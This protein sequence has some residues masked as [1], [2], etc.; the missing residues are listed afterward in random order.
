MHSLTEQ[1]KGRKCSFWELI[2]EYFIE[3]PIIQRDY[4]QGR[5]TGKA[6]EIRKKFLPDLVNAIKNNNP[7][8]LDFIYGSVKEGV[9]QP[10]DGQQR[11][12]TLFLLHWYIAQKEKQLNAEVTEQLQK[13]TY[14]TRTSSR[15]FCTGLVKEGANLGKGSDISEK[16]KDASWFFLAWQKDPTIKAMLTM[17]RAIEKEL[18]KD[19]ES[20]NDF[21]KKLTAEQ[22]AP[23]TFSFIELE[24]FGLSDDLYVK[25]N[26][27]GKELTDFENFKAKFEQH[28]EK[29]DKNWE[30]GTKEIEKF[31]H[32]ADT[33]W[34]N[35]FW[36]YKDE[37]NKIDDAYLKFIAGV[38]INIY[39]ERQE[40]DEEIKQQTKEGLKEK[41]KTP[42]D[43]KD[44][45][46]E[47]IRLLNED[48]KSV[49]PEDFLSRDSFE[50]LK[51]Y[52]ECYATREAGKNKKY[53]PLYPK[54]NDYKLALWDY[55][56]E[57]S[58]LF[59][60]FN[61]KPT[62]PQRVL[63]YAQT[64][65]LLQHKDPFDPGSFSNWMRVAR[66][67]VENVN[68]DEARDFWSAIELIKEL[69]QGCGNIY[70]Y[71]A[72]EE[73]KSG[74]AGGQIRE[75]RTKASL[76][77]PNGEWNNEWYKYIADAEDHLLFR[78]SVRFLMNDY[79]YE[80]EIN[81]QKIN[82]ETF[83]KRLKIAKRIFNEKGIVEEYH[84]D[85][86]A[87]FL[88]SFV[89][90][91]VN[92]DMLSSVIFDGEKDTWKEMLKNNDLKSAVEQAL[93]NAV[94]YDRDRGKW[95]EIIE[96][97]NS[98]LPDDEQKKTHEI[99]YQ[100]KLLGVL[101]S[102]ETTGQYVYEWWWE[103]TCDGYWL[104]GYYQR[105]HNNILIQNKKG[106][107]QRNKIL[108][109]LIDN[110]KI[111]LVDPDQRMKI[112]EKEIPFFYGGWIELL[113]KKKKFFWNPN[114]TIGLELENGEWKNSE[115]LKTSDNITSVLDKLLETDP[116]L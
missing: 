48:F 8:E 23:I 84:K 17:L 2:E 76:I 24:H 77:S 37:K 13:F 21:W 33:A 73:I 93:D 107:T 116:Q 3:I 59:K 20:S 85:G 55:C 11:L 9:L 61:N 88:R 16:I 102:Q 51:N 10:L 49:K 92:W 79:P 63:F 22:D 80:G 40:I 42:N 89:S 87:L 67:I 103:G 18:N 25:M 28:I 68:I 50:D 53:D 60:K 90:K 104:H 29:K 30:R 54:N 31:S 101:A 43:D 69:S 65:Y 109:K 113:Y 97:E 71:L 57:E 14:E 108:E 110:R 34:T 75:E 7:L 58:T 26:D 66:N 56:D 19:K 111:E 5:K 62:Y 1:N 112:E 72:K 81:V 52:L 35:L 39:A 38:V 32:K 105:S 114:N 78:G 64:K 106:K 91:M 41:G 36:K 99:L 15:E 100:S 95:F 27:R 83:K 47:R 44:I 46:R 96:S 115:L 74:L 6:P 98:T 94:E 12:T 86:E 4:A 45:I 82:I 70:E